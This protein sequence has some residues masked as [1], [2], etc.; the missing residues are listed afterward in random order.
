MNDRMIRR[1]SRFVTQILVRKMNLKEYSAQ[2][3]EQLSQIESLLGS[4][5]ALSWNVKSLRDQCDKVILK[6]TQSLESAS[7]NLSPSQRSSRNRFL[8]ATQSTVEFLNNSGLLPED[9]PGLYR[10]EEQTQGH[11]T[12]EI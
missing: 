5:T 7:L 3:A 11:S 12:Q 9:D 1:L 4:Q 2:L 8:A 6:V 10:Q